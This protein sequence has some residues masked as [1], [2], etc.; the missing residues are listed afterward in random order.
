MKAYICNCFPPHGRG[1]GVSTGVPE[2]LLSQYLKTLKRPTFLREY[3]KL[4]RLCAAE[5][6]DHVGYL[7]RLAEREMIER[8][9]REVERCIKAA[10]LLRRH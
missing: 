1:S 7:T 9:R 5:G 3:Q 6:V 4:A 2:I 10:R 8:G